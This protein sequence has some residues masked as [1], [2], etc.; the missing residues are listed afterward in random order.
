VLGVGAEVVVGDLGAEGSGNMGAEAS[1][2]GVV[3]RRS[4]RSWRE[5]YQREKKSNSSPGA[6]KNAFTRAIWRRGLENVAPL[7]LHG[8]CQS[9]P[10]VGS[11][12]A[13]PT[14]GSL[15]RVEEADEWCWVSNM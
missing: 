10:R 5:P 2:K 7:L 9:C 14:R 15:H 1:S 12:G 8:L 3:A 4:R 11:V 6:P 13:Q